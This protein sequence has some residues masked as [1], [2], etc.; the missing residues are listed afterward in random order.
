[1]HDTWTEVIK[2]CGILVKRFSALGVDNTTLVLS[3]IYLFFFSIILSIP[4]WIVPGF[5]ALFCKEMRNKEKKERGNDCHW[6]LSNK[7]H[8]TQLRPLYSTF[9]TNIPPTPPPPPP[10][11]IPRI[12]IP[13]WWPT[14][15]NKVTGF[16]HIT[17]STL[18]W[19]IAA[20]TAPISRNAVVITD[21]QSSA[22][23]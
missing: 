19:S 7:C 2:E 16:F 12:D 15:L 4:L 9:N 21:S 3:Q 14:A 17:S 13:N 11:D 6:L 20:T 10:I 5:S 1:M 8:I 22:A 18:H 23:I